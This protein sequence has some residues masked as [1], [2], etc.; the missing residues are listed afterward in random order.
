MNS[1]KQRLLARHRRD[2]RLFLWSAVLLLA[3]IGVFVA[4]WLVPVLLL[5]GWVAHEAWF[6]DHL[7]YSPNDDYQY[8]FPPDTKPQSVSLVDGRLQLSAPPSRRAKR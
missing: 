6:A 7:F 2:K 3:A 1:R 8:T 5:L 4:W